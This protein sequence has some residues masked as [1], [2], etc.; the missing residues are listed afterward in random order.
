MHGAR[1]YLTWDGR[2]VDWEGEF[3]ANTNMMASFAYKNENLK[4]HPGLNSMEHK[5]YTNK[6]NRAQAP[7]IRIFTFVMDLE[8]TPKGLGAKEECCKVLRGKPK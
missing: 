2:D 5:C 6:S 8:A 7:K 4:M 3:V 1:V